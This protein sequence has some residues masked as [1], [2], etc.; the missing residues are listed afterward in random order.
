MEENIGVKN[1]RSIKE[2]WKE[3]ASCGLLSCACLPIACFPCMAM[4]GC[5]CSYGIVL[6]I[7]G[8]LL[9]SWGMKEIFDCIGAL[10]SFLPC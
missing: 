2:M 7:I 10:R 4:P 9:S 8:C 3:E 6:P 5:C 1:M